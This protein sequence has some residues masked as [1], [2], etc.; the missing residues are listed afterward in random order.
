MQASVI[1]LLQEKRG[2]AP[3]QISLI[4]EDLDDD[5][6]LAA[7]LKVARQ[8]EYGLPDIDSLL[9]GFKKEPSFSDFDGKRS[10]PT[11]VTIS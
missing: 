11:G 5:N 2:F 9:S 6:S 8:V 3:G 7:L 1:A 10:H 4:T